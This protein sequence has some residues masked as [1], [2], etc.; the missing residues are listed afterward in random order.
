MRYGVVRMSPELPSPT[1]QR[2]SIEIVG[3]DVF[4]E[5]RQ[6]TVG[7]Q[8]NLFQLLYGLRAGDEVLAHSLAA[9]EA[10]TGELA[11]LLR[12]F[13]ETGV[14]LRLTG[15]SQVETL[16]PSGPFPR[17][18]A[19]LADHEAHRLP[20]SV[21]RRR[22]RPREI[23]LT[24]HQLKYARDMH[25]RGHSMRAIGLLFQLAPNEVAELIRTRPDRVS[26][27]T[28]TSDGADLSLGG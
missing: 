25:R 8:R 7:S 5:E 10:T 18:L 2:R 24:Q 14:T 4:L 11:R 23:A 6:P 17:S 13:F 15:G 9:F 3:C 16:A 26:G 1:L 28:A 12:R 20:S 21:R 22:S 27:A 19:M